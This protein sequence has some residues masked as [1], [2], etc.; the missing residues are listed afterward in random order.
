MAPPQPPAAGQESL[1]ARL[2][3]PDLTGNGRFVAAN[4]IDS[5]ASGL[6]MAFM[7]V[8]FTGTTDLSLVS[9]GTSLTLG[10]ALALPA[11]ALAG[12]LLDRIGPRRVVAVGN[13]V[14]AV[15]F[16]SLL[17]AGSAW[18][19]VATQL[20]VQTGASLYWTSGSALVALVAQEHDRTRWFAF[21]RALRNV[22]IGFGGAV[23]ALAVA[24][25]DVNGLRALVALNAAGYLAAAWLIT[26]WRP[27]RESAP[28]T[29]APGAKAPPR[30]GYLMVLRDGA[31]MRL[32]AANVSFVLASMVLSILLG[33][34]ATDS[35]RVGAWVAGVL[36]TLNTAL[37]ATTQTVASRWI[38]RR[39]TTRVIALAAVVNAVAFTVFA[40]LG[41]LP[42]WAV[43]VGLPAAVIVYTL[44]E[45]LGSPPMGE[46]SV[47]L[48]PA[49]ARGRYLGVFQLSWTLGG[50]IAP[51][52]LT[53]LLSWGPAWP[54]LFLAAVSVLSVPLVLSLESRVRRGTDH[55]SPP[56]GSAEPAP[57][58]TAL[59]GNPS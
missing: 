52:A 46:L 4:V 10:Y 39:R 9:V 51:A 13:L 3:F 40:V 44:A 29:S 14:S 54:W 59:E 6:V 22:G 45:I 38:E 25:A 17:L 8:Y 33:L 34:Y 35:L 53:T 18:Q 43:A 47:A 5:L 2:G 16:V 41:V 57:D 12:W 50:V 1:V 24:V 26:S 30:A 7:V 56:A 27:V 42:S 28:D 58:T 32:V 48:A 20:V 19:I 55:A 15:G 36:I 23:A 31:Y 37:V 21:I 11:P 49:H